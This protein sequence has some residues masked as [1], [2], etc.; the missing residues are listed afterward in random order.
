MLTLGITGGIGS[1]KTYVAGL[2]ER[3]GVPVYYTDTAA[4]R[5]MNTDEGIREALTA[6]IGAD[7]YLPGGGLDK[8]VVAAYLFADSRHAGQVNGIVHPAVRR[9]FRLWAARQTAPIV[10]MECAILF[11]SGFDTL[12]DAVVAV[13]APVEV[14]IRRAMQRDSA[15][16][17][18]VRARMAA[19]W[20]DDERRARANYIIYNDGRADVEHETDLLLERLGR[21]YSLFEE[22]KD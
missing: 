4:R 20:T 11:E 17:V 21:S 6:L 9:D 3:R 1:G 10:A 13:C 15:T 14:R 5:L 22:S 8:A 18:Q 19:Q 16:E 7:A 12:V 2:M